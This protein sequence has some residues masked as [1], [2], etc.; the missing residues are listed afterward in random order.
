MIMTAEEV[1]RAPAASEAAAVS[2]PLFA[3]QK[4]TRPFRARHLL[5]TR[6][7]SLSLRRQCAILLPP[8]GPRLTPV[9]PSDSFCNT[10]RAPDAASSSLFR[11]D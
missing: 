1:R 11:K 9:T 7:I 8:T 3:I 5:L 10:H 6:S 2:F 4:S